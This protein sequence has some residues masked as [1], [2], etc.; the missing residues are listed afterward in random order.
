M[1]SQPRAVTLFR[2]SLSSHLHAKGETCPWCEQE[3]PPEKLEAISGKIALREHEQSLAITARLQQKFE[4]ERMEAEAIGKANLES[5]RCQSA[6]REA[7]AREEAR[8]IAETAAAEKIAV[9][10]T[11]RQQLEAALQTKM[12]RSRPRARLRT[13]PSLITRP[14]FRGNA[15]RAR[16]ALAAAKAECGGPMNSLSAQKRGGLPE[17]P[18]LRNLLR[19]RRDSR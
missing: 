18:W 16:A 4:A 7:A 17:P 12:S 8:K 13:K 1:I 19:A 9:A 10:E 3:I 2:P 6:A 14:N 5:E 11:N 15:R